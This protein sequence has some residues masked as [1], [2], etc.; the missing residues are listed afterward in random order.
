MAQLFVN[1]ASST[2]AGTIT[3]GQTT[4]A[5]QSGDAAKFPNPSNPDYFLATVADA[6]G[7]VEIMRCTARSGATLTV[8]RAQEGTTAF[9]F[10]SGARV[11][12]RLTAGTMTDKETRLAAAE[13]G[14][15]HH[16]AKGANI[17]AASTTNIGA[18]TGE[19]VH[20][21]GNTQI[22]SFGTAAAGVRRELVFDGTP[23]IKNNA[24]I[25]LGGA[26]IVAEAN[27]V[28]ELRSEGSG[29]WRLMN[30][31]RPFIMPNFIGIVFEDP[32]PTLAPGFI[33]AAG[34]LLNR[35]T[36][37]ALFAKYGTLYGAGDGSTTF[38]VPDDRGRVV[39]GQDDMLGTSANRLTGQAG[40]VDGDVLG[41][42]GGAETHALT[43]AQTGPHTHT[44]TTNNGGV[45]HNHG[46]IPNISGT[47]AIDFGGQT[48]A[49]PPNFG[50]ILNTTGA[51]Q[52]LHTHGFTTDS[53]GGGAAHNNVQPT[54]IRNKVIYTGV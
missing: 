17:V 27:A 29:V 46:G 20:I 47:V 7:N 14:V 1:N 3:A 19:F 53:A 42:T 34:Q 2:L 28:A 31:K 52:F 12:C 48:Q 21:T 6:L 10:T 22:D 51:S 5:V 45:D 50:N 15:A 32:S 4:I 54:I 39:A 33:Y 41:A 49:S 37:A 38:G 11:D 40:G 25:L 13:A 36:Y 9:A 30:F 8:T 43:G 23:T 26:D 24:N 44:G 35:N 18:A 16:S